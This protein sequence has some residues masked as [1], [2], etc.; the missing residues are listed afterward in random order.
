MSAGC[1][2]INGIL[3]C[4]LQLYLIR[5]VLEERR[6]LY[7][8]SEVVKLFSEIVLY[9][10]LKAFCFLS[11]SEFF[12]F[13][14]WGQ[15]VL[16]EKEWLAR[17]LAFWYDMEVFLDDSVSD[18]PLKFT[19]EKTKPVWLIKNVFFKIQVRCWYNPT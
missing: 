10:L 9:T 4:Y 12:T 11:N 18:K 8:F 1:Q 5:L 19:R 13:C 14:K 6:L 2:L 17:L 3:L 16:S 15:C 7:E